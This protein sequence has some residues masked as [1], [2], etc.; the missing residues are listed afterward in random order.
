MVTNLV[1]VTNTVIVTVTNYIVTTNTV[2]ATNGP[3][4]EAKR[5]WWRKARVS[6]PPPEL[7]WV[8]PA[9]PFDWIQL[10]SGE[11]LKGRLQALQERQLEFDSEELK[12]QTFDW[13]DIRQVRSPRTLD[14]LF[15]DGNKVSG[16]VTVTPEQV[17]VGGAAPQ[18][19]PRDQ[20]QSIT[21]GGSRERNYWS[22]DVALGLTL[23]QGNTES[24]EYN[25]QAHLQ[26]RTPSTRLSFD[27]IG[28][29]SSVEGVESA[30]NQRVNTEFDLWLSRRFYLITP[31]AEY[32]ADPFQNLETRITGGVGVGYDLID[33]PNLNWNITAG[34]AYQQAWFESSQPGE[35][36]EKGTGALA[37]GSRFDWDITSRIELILEYRGQYTSRDVGETT[38]HSVGTL[39][40]ELTKRLDLDVSLVW[41]SAWCKASRST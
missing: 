13:K 18:S 12:D 28:N 40:L 16:P 21:P 15:V 30:N 3:V 38:H 25:A 35:P 2:I 1:V 7:S 22:G 27:Y 11:W 19:H 36:A 4:A 24:V 6:V 10:K 34:P 9:D 20:L 29:V 8:P 32:Y 14:V 23:R 39:S 26:R 33:R 41:P 37:F 17:A 31:F 5:R